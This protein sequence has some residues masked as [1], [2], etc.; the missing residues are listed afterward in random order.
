MKRV[1]DFVRREA[2][3]CGGAGLALVLAMAPWWHN[4]G[5]LRDF[6]DYGYMMVASYRIGAGERPFVDFVAPLQTL[7]FRMN[8]WADQLFGGT[9]VA[10]TLGNAVLITLA[11]VL[12]V[13]A[14]RRW[15]AAPGALLL[16]WVMVVGTAGQHTIIWYNSLG[17]LLA[18]AVAWGAAAAPVWRRRDWGWHVVVVAGLVLS[19]MNKLNYH[20]IT[21]VAALAWP[22]RAGLLGREHW[23]RVGATVAGW[24]LVGTVV[25]WSI[26]LA[27]TGATP[28]QWWENVIGAA[29]SSRG[30]HLAAVFSTEFYLRPMHDYYGAYL[31]PVGAILVLWL[32]AA[33]G[34][35]W[36]GRSWLDRALLV[37]AAV[38]VWGAVAGLLATNYEI[39]YV[40]LT[41]GMVLLIGIWVGFELPRRGWGVMVGLFAPV[42]LLGVVFWQSAW[43]GQRS[44]F[45]FERPPR[46]EW[47]E[48]RDGDGTY[49]YMAGVKI[50]PALADS[51]EQLAER[52]G[53]PGDPATQH[54]YFFGS[55][56]EWLRRVWETDTIKHIPI[57]VEPL[58]YGPKE[59]LLLEEAFSYPP[60]FDFVVGMDNWTDWPGDIDEFIDDRGIAS[61]LGKF[62]VWDLRGNKQETWLPPRDDAIQVVNRYGSNMD[63]RLV[64]LDG[65]VQF[66]QPIEAG[67]PLLGVVRG[68]GSFLFR[69]EA[70]VME[71][72]YALRRLEGT[73]PNL[74]LSATY[75]VEVIDPMTRMGVGK[76]WEGEL[77][78]PPGE[79]FVSA[80]QAVQVAGRGA[81]FEVTVAD[82]SDGAVAAGWF[83]PRVQHS[84]GVSPQSPQ[85]RSPVLPETSGGEA[86]WA[87]AL[88]PPE[89][90]K[91][92]TVVVR[93]GQALDGGLALERGGELWF[94]SAK[95][96]AEW[97]M[98]FRAL[99]TEVGGGDPVLRVVWYEAGR[100][101]ILTQ[102]VVEK[103]DSAQRFRAWSP[104]NEG[105]FGV[106][107]DR[108]AIKPGVWLQLESFEAP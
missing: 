18:A 88:F 90:A 22:V 64:E 55:G 106:L 36:R 99:P 108:D 107:V 73:D 92:V 77:I 91:D 49:A 8:T 20:A 67:K 35:G 83:L 12:V 96:I 65:N 103:G 5:F 10:L 23:G 6:F 84:A 31:R 104:E 27:W 60:R 48:L 59:R 42:M 66:L 14:M 32:V 86:G 4:R 82:A 45:G 61:T 16:G 75:S 43:V 21:L 33:V 63:G 78:L 37:A 72:E 29:F 94:R 30:G 100:I 89:L 38:Y 97:W 26:E 69:G 53:P 54:R 98:S 56:T 105:W 79:V 85:L 80:K 24:L 2:W 101:E 62:T 52:L 51:L 25:P 7:T 39:A 9:F 3:W 17:T 34:L 102:L 70:H 58:G 74:E 93:G 11:L 68:F 71:G 81:R 50:P 41:T 76:A 28:A 44:L 47:R 19:G 1:F 87:E 95:E 40:A 13:A 15:F 46:A 57:P